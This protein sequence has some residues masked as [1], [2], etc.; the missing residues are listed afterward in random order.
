MISSTLWSLFS[1][2]LIIPSDEALQTVSKPSPD[3]QR[4]V[5]SKNM[6]AGGSQEKCK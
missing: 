4:N 5:K 1:S 2:S 6:R 3:S